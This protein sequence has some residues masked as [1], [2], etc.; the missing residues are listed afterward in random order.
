[1]NVELKP[2]LEHRLQAIAR[3]RSQSLSGLV[4][5]GMLSY[6]NALENESSWVESTQETRL[7]SASG[8][9]KTLRNGLLQMV[10]KAQGQVRWANLPDP[11]GW[12]PF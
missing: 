4:E 9:R 11:L 10:D 1:M 2:E 8:P 12:R 5:E 3:E 6:L 7:L